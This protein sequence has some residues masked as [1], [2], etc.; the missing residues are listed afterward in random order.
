MGACGERAVSQRTEKQK[1]TTD[2][3][4]NKKIYIVPYCHPDW[5]WGFS[6]H[7]HE[8]RYVLVMEEAM[9]LIKRHPDFRW[10]MDTYIT[11]LEPFLRM[12]PDRMKELVKSVHA[13][14]IAVCGTFTNLRPNL[15]GEETQIRDIQIGKHL[16]RKLFP[17]AD[18]SVYAS[19]VDVSL[20]HY[21]MPQLLALSGY[22]YFRFWRPHGALSAKKI[23]LEFIWKGLDGSRITCSRGCYSGLGQAD[24][25]DADVRKE[26]AQDHALSPT[27][28]R[29][30]SQGADDARPLRSP[31]MDQKINLQ[32]FINAWNKSENALILFGTPQEFFRELEAYLHELPVVSVNLDPCD[33]AYNVGWG[34]TGGL[35]WY[36]Q[37]N[38]RLLGETEVWQTLA[39]LNG[40]PY[41]EQAMDRCWRDHLIT[42]AHAT[43][44]LF[45]EDY[46]AMLGRAH[47]VELNASDR[48]QCAIA[49]LAKCIAT[50]SSDEVV[51]FNPLPF[52]RTEYVRLN[53]V[54]SK[55]AEGLSLRDGTNREIMFQ[56]VDKNERGIT[57]QQGPNHRAWEY[58]LVAKVNL[59]P[60]GY[61]A[62]SVS[63]KSQKHSPRQSSCQVEW[64][65]HAV[66]GIKCQGR[67][68]QAKAGASFGM[69]R[70]H[71]VDTT[72]GTLHVGPITNTEAVVWSKTEQLENGP[73][74]ARYLSEGFVRGHRIYRNVYVW[75][76][77][78]R[79]EF[80][81][82][83]N[84][85]KDDGFLT[86]EWPVFGDTLYA[87]FPFGV[88]PKR[89]EGEPFEEGGNI[90]E[91]QRPG[92][93][94]AKSFV[95]MFDGAQS[96][97]YLNQDATH[98]Y[99]RQTRMMANI[100][101]NQV[102]RLSGWERFVTHKM[103]GEGTHRFV[104]HLIFHSGNWQSCHLPRRAQSLFQAPEYWQVD[105]KQHGKL[106][107]RHS[108]V[109]L[110]PENLVLT[111]LRCEGRHV[112]M[113][114]YE[115]EGKNGTARIVLPFTPQM[116]DK[117]DLDG[118]RMEH[119][120]IGTQ[121]KV[122]V[123][124]WE[125]V[126]LRFRLLT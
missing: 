77:E 122:A 43:Q 126:T 101:L 71:E 11:Q 87:D 5:A 17:R 42:C 28:L 41:D 18:L 14:K 1:Q 68:Y 16:Y 73:L 21:Q 55:G 99:W 115:T 69:M 85:Q 76:D 44:W 57:G 52:E 59:P 125:I 111:A 94:F 104:S 37:M 4:M 9:D 95:S 105:G 51:I 8:K 114:F 53:L 45:E 7:W 106:P 60:T 70:Y 93:F 29:W 64:Q 75:Y 23:P 39:S 31:Y 34:G 26:L 20:G 58:Q 47:S 119:I 50:R 32:R 118:N 15:V 3:S 67:V 84:A 81:I 10:Y 48:K 91:R 83:V 96:I 112:L 123:R 79:L 62:V 80:K 103:L 78:P 90:I 36:R 19:T 72:K 86:I 110:E 24:Q 124:P 46:A 98:Y 49:A 30:I 121:V 100:L 97:S 108:F 56:I 22:R 63:N 12:R 113:R 74:Y 33:V 65:R 117:I 38:D 27:G 109:S 61:T 102:T 35:F 25:I 92:L 82:E 2:T 107:G 6:R 54:F 116:A 120:E 66:I 89:L 13:G 88:E 40:R